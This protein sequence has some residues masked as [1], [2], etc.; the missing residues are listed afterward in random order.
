L[1]CVSGSKVQGSGIGYGWDWGWDW[2]RGWVGVKVM[3]YSLGFR[4]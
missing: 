1:A 4:I 2:R 3:V